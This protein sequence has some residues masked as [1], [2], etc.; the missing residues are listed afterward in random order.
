[1]GRMDFGTALWNQ[2]ESVRS[3][4]DR[5]LRL[6]AAVDRPNDL[7]FG[8]WVGLYAFCLEFAPDFITE[9][10]RGYG[11]STCVFTEVAN[12]LRARGKMTTVVS[13]GYDSEEAWRTRTAPRL[14]ATVSRDWFE[15]L[16]VLQQDI[17]ETQCSAMVAP[18]DR[19][20]VFWDVHGRDLA[21]Y[22]LAELMPA[23]RGK[24]HVVAVHDIADA[25]HL[26]IDPAYEGEE[27]HPA[28]WYGHLVSAFDEVLVLGDFCARNGIAIRTP[29]ESLNAG[30]LHNQEKCVE[31]ERMWGIDVA[32]SA[33][34]A[35]DGWVYFDLNDR[36]N[37]EQA[38]AFPKY[39]SAKQSVVTQVTRKIAARHL[40]IGPQARRLR[41]LAGNLI[42]SARRRA[43]RAS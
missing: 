4:K 34:Q 21:T 12:Q 35:A 14:T 11:N 19:V 24:E 26:K 20:F 6:Y 10:G 39:T 1:M 17:L 32:R 2:R 36:R 3:G 25:R 8:Q 15:P 23:L 37:P 7:S 29:N 31:L 5:L 41:R 38:L 9:L 33:L 27:G 28:V 13:I 40:V 22:V 43:R 16:E 30:L 18:A 42:A